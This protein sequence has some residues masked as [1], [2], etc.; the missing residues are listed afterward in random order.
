MDFIDCLNIGIVITAILKRFFSRTGHFHDSLNHL[1]KN[2]GT[3]GFGG[4]A[5][6]GPLPPDSY[7]AC[8][9]APLWRSPMW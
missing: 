2:L 3:L 9:I 1:M 7:S 6:S 8:R 5:T 4:M